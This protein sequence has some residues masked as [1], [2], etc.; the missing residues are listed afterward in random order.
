MELDGLPLMVMPLSA[1]TF[2]FDLMTPKPNH[3]VSAPGPGTY[4]T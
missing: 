1:V 3:Y 2:I 4:M